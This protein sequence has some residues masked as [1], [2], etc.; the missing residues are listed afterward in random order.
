MPHLHH[1]LLPL[2]IQQQ[3]TME[4]HRRHH[5]QEQLPLH[6]AQRLP[7]HTAHPRQAEVNIHNFSTLQP[8]IVLTPRQI[9]AN[10]VPAATD[11]TPPQTQTRPHRPAAPP[12]AKNPGAKSLDATVIADETPTTPTTSTIHLAAAAAKMTDAAIRAMATSQTTGTTA[13]RATTS[14][15]ATDAGMIA[16]TTCSINHRRPRG[17]IRAMMIGMRHETAGTMIVVRE[18]GAGR[19]L[20][21]QG[22]LSGSARR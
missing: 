19:W 14:R 18:V 1:R 21:S 3:Q 7:H 22:S 9:P 15:A 10:L 13:R 17:A 12:A 6:P 5:L 20:G 8:Y 16:T 2:D 11:H 4:H